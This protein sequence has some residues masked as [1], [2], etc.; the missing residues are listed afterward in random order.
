MDSQ[1]RWG[2]HSGWDMSDVTP[3]PSTH[4]EFRHDLWHLDNSVLT[5]WCSLKV[6]LTRVTWCPQRQ[7]LGPTPRLRSRW[8]SWGHCIWAFCAPLLLRHQRLGY[9]CQLKAVDASALQDILRLMMKLVLLRVT[10]LGLAENPFA[11][12]RSQLD[13]VMA[14]SRSTEICVLLI[15]ERK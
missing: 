11:S 13:T 3:F 4:F 14:Y 7:L 6:L 15:C 8:C 12:R 9:V 10:F 1:N 2:P 5:R